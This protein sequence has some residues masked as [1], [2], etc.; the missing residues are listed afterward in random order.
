MTL[1]QQ[2]NIM[3]FDELMLLIDC[4]IS[5]DLVTAVTPLL[6][7]RAVSKT[8]SLGFGLLAQVAQSS[9]GEGK[10]G[11]SIR[12]STLSELIFLNQLYLWSKTT[13]KES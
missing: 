12:K 3:E 5:V 1:S 2:I 4:G 10:V 8:R 6:L 7:F 13:D 9:E 11:S